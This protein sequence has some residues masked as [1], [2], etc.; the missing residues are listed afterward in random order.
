MGSR[1]KLLESCG[2]RVEVFSEPEQ[3]TRFGFVWPKE[4]V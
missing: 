4:V 1:E 3:G 2:G